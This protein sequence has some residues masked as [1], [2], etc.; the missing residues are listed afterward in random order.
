[1]ENLA[2]Q[3]L[4]QRKRDIAFCLLKEKVKSNTFFDFGIS[5]R[6]MAPILL[7]GDIYTVRNVAPQ[8]LRKGDIILFKMNDTLIVHRYIYKFQKENNRIKLITK[9][10]N[11]PFFDQWLVSSDELF[12]KV[13]LIKKKQKEINLEGIFWKIINYLLALVSSVQVYLLDFFRQIKK[14]LFGNRNL[15]Y[16]S[17][18]K[19]SIIS[20]LSLLLKT[21][22]NI[23]CF[24]S[25]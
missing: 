15:R 21:I 17:F 16:V 4:E 18:I 23:S 24:A 6:S 2:C 12:G 5:S 25:R 9:G 19:K 10:D 14:F 22:V 7:P 1:M 13:I 8:K 11:L 3:N 20:S